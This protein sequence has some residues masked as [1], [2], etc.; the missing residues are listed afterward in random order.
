MRKGG[1]FL[2]GQPKADRAIAYCHSAQHQGYISE[3]ILKA[4]G[5][6]GKNCPYLEKYEDKPYWI[7]RARKKAEKK[8]RKEEL[9]SPSFA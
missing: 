8:A 5:C 9:Y 7:E 3:K 4:H 1:K 6:L 2:G